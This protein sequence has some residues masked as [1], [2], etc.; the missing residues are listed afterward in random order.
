[1]TAT[2]MHS[3]LARAIS[4]VRGYLRGH[5]MKIPLSTLIGYLIFSGGLALAQQPLPLPVG[6]P[7][8][9]NASAKS[10]ANLTARRDGPVLEAVAQE[11]TPQPKVPPLPATLERDRPN[12]A[13]E[14]RRNDDTAPSPSG[15]ASATTDPLPRKP[16]N[17]IP[18]YGPAEPYGP[19]EPE[20]AQP[21]HQGP[22]SRDGPAVAPNDPSRVARLAARLTGGRTGAGAPV[23]AGPAIVRDE[24]SNPRPWTG[25]G[26][27][28][29]E[30]PPRRRPWLSFLSWFHRCD[31]EEVESESYTRAEQ[32]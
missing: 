25:P 11:P 30:P 10:P 4:T 6:D 13:V 22:G 14:H 1:M 5:W 7:T 16:D 12:S 8:G 31:C 15:P 32:R 2:S 28:P 19:R 3:A 23:W 17:V 29:Y 20:V 26:V 18:H 24:M 27:A 9:R 21:W